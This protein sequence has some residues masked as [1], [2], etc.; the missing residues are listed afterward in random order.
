[1]APA[2]E[3]LHVGGRDLALLEHFEREQEILR[4]TCPCACPYRP[5]SPAP[6][7]RCGCRRRGRNRFRGRRSPARRRAARRIRCSIAVKRRAVLVEELRPSRGEPLDRRLFEVV[8]RRLHEFRLPGPRLGAA[9]NDEIG[10]RQIGLEPARRHVERRARD[11]ERLRLRPQRLQESTG[12]AASACVCVVTPARIRSAA[13]R[14]KRNDSHRPGLSPAR[15]PNASVT[16][17]GLAR[18]PRRH[19]LLKARPRRQP[20]EISRKRL[21]C[22]DRGA[23]I[24]ESS[25]D[26]PGSAS[27]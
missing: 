2:Q 7:W 19:G 20:V 15:R 17:P 23:R 12:S 3:L 14:K 26:R 18:R 11:A 1:M 10:Q 4:G 8:G 5:A 9:G 27:H 25:S 16:R 21:C 6:G 22:R 13:Q 24:R